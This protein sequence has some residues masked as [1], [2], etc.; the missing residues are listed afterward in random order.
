MDFSHLEDLDLEYECVLRNIDKNSPNVLK[1]LNDHQKDASSLDFDAVSRGKVLRGG[2]NSEITLI[3]D[4][5]EI[6]ERSVNDAIAEGDLSRL[7]VYE[8]RLNHLLNRLN[9]LDKMKPDLPVLG[10]LR[11]EIEK[12]L[13]QARDAMHNVSG[14]PPE[15]LHNPF[16]VE[17]LAYNDEAENVDQ[18]LNVSNRNTNTGTI[19]RI[20]NQTQSNIQSNIRRPVSRSPGTTLAYRSEGASQN[21]PNQ[22]TNSQRNQSRAITDRRNVRQDDRVVSSRNT[23]RASTTGTQYRPIGQ[24]QSNS[25][26]SNR[27]RNNFSS[28]SDRNRPNPINRNNNNLNRNE[29]PNVERNPE[30]QQ[31]NRL[32]SK[33]PLA[34][35]TVKFEGKDSVLTVDEFIFR[36][37]IMAEGENITDRALASGLHY[38]LAGN[39]LTWYWLFKR[40]NRQ[41][42]WVEL[43][44]ALR[45]EFRSRDTDYEIRKRADSMKQTA[46][47]TFGEFKLRVEAEI[48]KLRNPI[49][50]EDKLAMLKRN[51]KPELRRALFYRHVRTTTELARLCRDF[52]KLTAQLGEDRQ[53]MSNIRRSVHEIESVDTNPN[54]YDEQSSNFQPLTGEDEV[55]NY[56]DHEI[57]QINST[58]RSTFAICWNCKDIGHLFKDCS[59]QIAPGKVFCFGCGTPDVLKPNCSRCKANPNWRPNSSMQGNRG[60]AVMMNS[61]RGKSANRPQ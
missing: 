44:D 51:V 15:A 4:K 54:H 35:W 1:K 29:P 14:P 52:E 37:E 56:F 32:S 36:V 2:L 43:Q 34:L 48:A 28:N 60:S 30:I 55:E 50:E 8:S 12:M 10:L 3:T 59:I 11:T 47:E 40:Q 22:F 19:P 31:P 39:A 25:S 46:R 41:A 18:N 49:R 13:E 38:L 58:N 26:I 45:V 61:A 20:Q 5:G 27:I 7:E 42:S 16:R 9:V 17:A 53:P 57:A 23:S 6:I 24:S 21:R 33:N